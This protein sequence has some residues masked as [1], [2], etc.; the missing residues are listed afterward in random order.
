[1]RPVFDDTSV[2]YDNDP[3]Y[4]MDGGEAMGNDDRRPPFCEIVQ[5]LPNLHFGL[6]VDIGRGLVEHDDRG[7][8]QDHTGNRYTLPLADRE[9][10]PALSNPCI[11]PIRKCHDKVVR[12]SHL[13]RSFN[14][15][16]PGQEVSVQNILSHRTIEQERLLLDQPDL[17]SK[18]GYG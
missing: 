17:T 5:R 7:I 8:L 11:V 10:H 3:I 6:L 12:A 14:L 18:K 4:A 13:R 15:V 1:M 9:F 16:L 2:V